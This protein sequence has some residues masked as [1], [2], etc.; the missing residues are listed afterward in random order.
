MNLSGHL[1]LLTEINKRKRKENE[2]IMNFALWLETFRRVENSTFLQAN[3]ILRYQYTWLKFRY[4]DPLILR[5]ID[6]YLV[7]F[8][9]IRD[10]EDLK[11]NANSTRKYFNEEIELPSSLSLLN[12]AQALD[13]TW[14]ESESLSF[15]KPYSR[16]IKYL[17]LDTETVDLTTALPNLQSLCLS[18]EYF[19]TGIPFSAALTSPSLRR[20]VLTEDQ[21][22]VWP[23]LNK[24]LLLNPQLSQVYL[25]FEAPSDLKTKLRMLQ[26]RQQIQTLSLTLYTFQ[27]LTFLQEL[28]NLRTLSCRCSIELC[29]QIKYPKVQNLEL[30]D[31]NLEART[32]IEI[33]LGEPLIQNL[34]IQYPWP[35]ESW[36]STLKIATPLNNL[37]LEARTKEHFVWANIKEVQYRYLSCENVLASQNNVS[38]VSMLRTFPSDFLQISWRILFALARKGSNIRTDNLR[39][40]V[41][42][43]SLEQGMKIDALTRTEFDTHR[44]V[45]QFFQLD[46]RSLD[47]EV[48]FVESSNPN[49]SKALL[50][51]IS[52][53]ITFFVRNN[54]SGKKA[55]IRIALMGED[56]RLRNLLEE[57]IASTPENIILL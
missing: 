24:L 43:I 7:P 3:Q 4:L 32:G 45:S 30:L 6:H 28:K 55:Q 2:Q 29:S 40:G 26:K 1:I 56:R 16:Q 19:S 17:N 48:N 38:S 22:R 11:L 53:L 36:S 52:N 27:D 47:L 5:E 23:W 31:S 41:F 12:C 25:C 51:T 9:L 46:F 50:K 39:C 8:F 54:L 13:V 33:D 15:W 35:Y 34:K 21:P 20:I 14:L 37:I 49:Y 57:K 18:N 44:E 42:L 10:N